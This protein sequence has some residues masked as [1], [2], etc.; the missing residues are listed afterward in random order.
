[1]SL[2]DYT[3]VKVA[4]TQLLIKLMG[5]LTHEFVGGS[6]VISTGLQMLLALITVTGH[7][8]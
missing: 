8:Q 6:K 4:A 2:D 7:S 1:M 3:K 5:F